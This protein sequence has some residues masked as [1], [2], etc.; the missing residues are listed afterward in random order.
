M[1]VNVDF[2]K[3]CDI[4]YGSGTNYN[5]DKG[6]K[7]CLS[8]GGIGE[9]TTELGD[10]LIKFLNSKIGNKVIKSII[11]DINNERNF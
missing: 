11:E 6:G 8:C 2:I 7:K 4:C 5:Q 1:E 3:E 9:K 10:A